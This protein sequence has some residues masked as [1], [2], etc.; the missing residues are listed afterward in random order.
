MFKT[1]YKYYKYIIILFELINV[2]IIMQS[3]I[4]NILRE[5]LNKFYIIYL[6]NILIFLNN[7]KEHVGHI[8]K[9]LKILKKTKF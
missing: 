2:L 1:K 8:T 3:L 5:Y 9:I 7:K 4:N 6:N